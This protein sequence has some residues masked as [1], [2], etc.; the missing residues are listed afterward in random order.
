MCCDIVGDLTAAIVCAMEVLTTMCEFTL[1]G[2]VLDDNE[3]VRGMT[4]PLFCE[5][6]DDDIWG[7]SGGVGLITQSYCS[8]ESVKGSSNTLTEKIHIK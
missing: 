5:H 8:D 1:M 3:D 6:R 2:D 4:N 7:D